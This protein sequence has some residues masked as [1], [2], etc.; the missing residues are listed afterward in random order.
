MTYVLTT[1]DPA[2]LKNILST[3]EI[4]CFL[5]EPI[6][7]AV[8]GMKK[9]SQKGLDQMVALCRANSVITIADEVMTG[10]G[11][12]G[13]NFAVENL[14]NRPGFIHCDSRSIQA[15]LCR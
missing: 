9:H 3:G 6:I 10:M 5:F 7:Q 14:K 2:E 8:N 4:A 13:P 12:L 15:F 1:I 11:R